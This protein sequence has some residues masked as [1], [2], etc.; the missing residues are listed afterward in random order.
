[1]HCQSAC[2]L[3]SDCIQGTQLMEGQLPVQV[4]DG[5]VGQGAECT[6]DA[7]HN[8]MDHTAQLL[9]LWYVSAAGHGNLQATVARM[10]AMLIH[11][12]LIQC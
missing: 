5:H 10:H 2:V 6:V 9:I 8:L 7:T 12:M 11:A 1:M 4:V 3:T